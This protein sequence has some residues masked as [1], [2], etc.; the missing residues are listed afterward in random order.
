LAEGRVTGEVTRAEATLETL[1]H[2]C[3]LRKQVVSITEGA[4]SQ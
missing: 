1:M 4:V 3:T 2:Y